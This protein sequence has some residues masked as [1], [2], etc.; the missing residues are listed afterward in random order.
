MAKASLSKE[1]K[2]VDKKICIVDGCE[3]Q[4]TRIDGYC[5]THNSRIRY[6]G[7]HTPD[8]FI[9][10]RIVGH[11][12][13]RKCKKQKPVSEYT[14][15]EGKKFGLSKTCNSCC[16]E[17]REIVNARDRLRR[18]IENPKLKP[19]GRR[20]D[21]KVV[22]I[23]YPLAN[24]KPPVVKKTVCPVDGC[25][26]K[27]KPKGAMCHRH[28]YMNKKYGIIHPIGF[29]NWKGICSSCGKE[30]LY[31]DFSNFGDISKI[32][33]PIKVCKKCK[34]K[35][36]KKM[37]K[38]RNPE[39][40]KARMNAHKRNREA[41]IR[42]NG[43]RHTANDI[44]FLLVMQKYKCATCKINIKN[45]YNVDHVIPLALG[46]SN[47]KDNLQLLCPACNRA[48]SAKHPVAFMQELGFLI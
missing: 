18:K 13:C 42:W 12:V 20:G 30:K 35:Q 43:G 44:L 36:K 40:Y 4:T 17:H 11:I 34:E 9:D 25:S 7:E 41:R 26:N 39:K 5:L 2:S 3:K 38:E 33:N 8:R 19:R 27:I 37:E 24:P 15:V 46:G 45:N 29:Y 32:E 6:F 22:M 23:P 14:E 16:D 48:K 28:E 31:K 21:E 1:K 10:P 47:D